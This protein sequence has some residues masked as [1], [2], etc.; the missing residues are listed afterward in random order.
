MGINKGENMRNALT[1]L[2]ISPPKIQLTLLAWFRCSRHGIFH[3][4][5]FGDIC[6]F[7]VGKRRTF[8]LSML[9]CLTQRVVLLCDIGRYVSRSIRYHLVCCETVMS[10]LNFNQNI[11]TE[12]KHCDSILGKI[13]T[14]VARRGEVESAM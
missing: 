10:E 8:G 5:V 13:A 6:T 4:R 11:C 7:Q 12:N 14:L 3:Y 1:S 9:T 2:R